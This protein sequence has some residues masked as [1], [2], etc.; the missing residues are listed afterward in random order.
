MTTSWAAAIPLDQA[1][2]A[3]PLRKQSDVE[4]CVADDLLWLRG[5]SW[6]DTLDRDLRKVLGAERFHCLEN[7]QTARWGCTLASGL[8]PQGPWTPL[9]QWLQPIAPP[10]IL[11]AK[12]AQRAPLRLVR[13]SAERAADLLVVDFPVWREY[14][15]SAPQIRLNLLSFAVSG[16]F[17]ALVR[18]IPLPPLPGARYAEMKGVAVPLGWSWS[19]AIDA[20]IVRQVLGLAEHDIALI[21]LEGVCE[22]VSSDDFVRATRSAVRLTEKEFGRE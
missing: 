6:T 12:I 8:L 3:A 10:T 2:G 18:G 7:N 1:L 15:V 4:V 11:P 22:I 19:P 21:T 16:D 13:S 14:A 9:I 20:E 5:S 17:R